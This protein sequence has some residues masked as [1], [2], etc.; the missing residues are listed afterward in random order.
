[1]HETSVHNTTADIIRFSIVVGYRNRELSRVKRSLEALANQTFTDFELIFVDYGS[2]AGYQKEV[3]ELTA[4][5]PFVQYVYTHTQGW[6]WNR[7]HAL[8]TGVR[9]AKGSIML[10]YDIDLLPER[11]FLEKVNRLSFENNFYTFSCFYLP[12]HFNYE[13]S[14]LE[15][16]GIHYEQN[17]V[18][19]CAVSREIVNEINGYDEYFMVWGAEDD[20]FYQRLKKSGLQHIHQSASAFNVFHQWHLTQAP[21]IPNTWY[22][23]MIH[24][25]SNKQYSSPRP[26][27][28]WGKQITMN[29]RVSF[30]QVNQFRYDVDLNVTNE[31]GF[32]LF[33]ELID[34]IYNPAVQTIRFEFNQLHKLH[35]NRHW[36][37]WLKSGS[38][39]KNVSEISLNDVLQ[40]VQ[41]FTGSCRQY[42]ADYRLHQNSNSLQL[43][44]VKQHAAF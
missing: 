44:L 26:Q 35:E 7:A 33:N 20:D 28:F 43:I 31:T 2:D 18:G 32:L 38:I 3:Q 40:F 30:S 34:A 9:F 42:I 13:Q 24:Y 5:Y 21:R 6:F 36:F 17:Y 16:D 12:Q 29:E 27:P 15:K 22:L 1:M 14:I 37:S 10:F 4:L 41:H 23:Q 39:K 25:L 8:N 11:L 19:L